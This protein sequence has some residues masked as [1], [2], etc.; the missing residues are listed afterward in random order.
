MSNTWI[1]P[2]NLGTD[3]FHLPP[4]GGEARYRLPEEMTEPGDREDSMDWIVGVSV[5]VS[6]P[7]HTIAL[8]C[9]TN[10]SEAAQG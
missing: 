6:S 9:N 5:V 10:I 7:V 1:L 2:A 8:A 3:V 4:G